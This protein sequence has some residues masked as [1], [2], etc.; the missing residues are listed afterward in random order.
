[1]DTPRVFPL[2]KPEGFAPAV[3][4][5]S[6]RFGADVIEFQ[7]AYV[8]VQS[9]DADDPAFARFLREIPELCST[10]KGP[11]HVDY[12]RFIDLAGF[13]TVVA[14]G[15]W[16]DR[17]SYQAWRAS[18]QVKTWWSDE[19]KTTGSAGYFFEPLPAVSD[20]LETIAFRQYI[21]GLA[22]CPMSTIEPM[23]ESGYWGAA[24]DRIPRSGTERF[25]PPAAEPLQ[26]ANEDSYG[27]RLAV[28]P[29]VNYCVIRSGVSWAA[30][31]E[32][33]LTSYRTNVEPKLNQGM[34]YLRDN[35]IEAGCWSLRQVRVVD[36]GGVE[37][38]ETYVAGHFV[39]LDDLER[40]AH[41]HPTHL[42]IFGQA[43]KE[44]VKYQ[45]DLEL[46]TYHEV[47]VVESPERFEYVN[48]H[49]RTGALGLLPATA[50]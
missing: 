6:A 32:E 43:Q 31:G 13:T 47:Y 24:R 30:C 23:A 49:P 44:R 1:M 12:A 14:N 8:G 34:A 7:T 50:I 21:R 28:L 10:A 41:H 5:Y 19:T 39:S 42:A 22:A 36:Q 46:R 27:R 29:P 15:Y 45:D 35:P 20:A 26:R 2:A 17:S 11:D 33:Q 3:Q 38:P 9:L 4:R 40:W 25:E 37:A 16:S 18:E 48:C